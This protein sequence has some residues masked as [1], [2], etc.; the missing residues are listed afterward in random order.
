MKISFGV[1]WLSFPERVDY[2]ENSN[3]RPSTD[4]SLIIYALSLT[5]YGTQQRDTRERRR[6]K[7]MQ[8]F[9]FLTVAKIWL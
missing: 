8:D 4:C 7:N 2:Q 6:E 9:Q 1:K 5:F 3:I